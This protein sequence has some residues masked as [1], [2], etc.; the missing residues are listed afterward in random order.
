[1]KERQFSKVKVTV[2]TRGKYK[3]RVTREQSHENREFKVQH[4]K[5]DLCDD[6]LP[7]CNDNIESYIDMKNEIN[8]SY[9]SEYDKQEPRLLLCAFCTKSTTYLVGLD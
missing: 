6:R 2:K 8:N 4:H 3:P 1:M 7:E 5:C 9:E